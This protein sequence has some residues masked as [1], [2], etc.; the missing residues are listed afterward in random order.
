[1]T[2]PLSSLD[3]NDLKMLR[4]DN[5]RIIELEKLLKDLTVKVNID[6]IDQIKMIFGMLDKKASLDD[7]YEAKSEITSNFS[8]NQT[9]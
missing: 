2:T 8:L 1:M 4:D 9:Y 5:K 3:D 7:L 6:L